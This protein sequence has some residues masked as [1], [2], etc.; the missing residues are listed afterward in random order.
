MKSTNNYIGYS[1][2]LI[3]LINFSI[4]CNKDDNQG[5]HIQFTEEGLQ[6]GVPAVVPDTI[7][8]NQGMSL[9]V[10]GD[11]IEDINSTYELILSG[12]RFSNVKKGTT[13][14]D[15][16]DG[17]LWVVMDVLDNNSNESRVLAIPGR[18]GNLFR[19]AILKYSLKNNRAKQNSNY[20]KKLPSNT[21]S[22]TA[23]DNEYNWDINQSNTIIES[24][25]LS[26]GIAIGTD[27]NG[28]FRL[29]FTDFVLL[30]NSSSPNTSIKIL[31][32][33]VTINNAFDLQAKFNP[34]ELILST[35][36]PII[37]PA[38]SVKEFDSA[39]YSTVDYDLVLGG[40][41][42][43]S[44]SGNSLVREIPLA[45]FIIIVPVS[46]LA[47]IEL[48]LDVFARATLDAVADFSISPRYTGVNDFVA[49]AEYE[50]IGTIPN[51]DFEFT[52]LER[53]T[54][55]A[56]VVNLETS[57]RVE[58]VPQASVY[59]YG[60]VGPTAEL[61]PFVDLNG[62]V[63]Y[64]PTNDLI[65]WDTAIDYGVSGRGTLDINVLGYENNEG[66]IQEL[67]EF[68][69][70]DIINENL[71]HAPSQSQIT[72][73]NNQIG[74]PNAQLPNPIEVLVRDSS[75]NPLSNVAVLFETED[76][77]GTFDSEYVYTDAIGVAVANWTL[78]NAE[79]TQ[80]GR[81]FV[82]DGNG[83]SIEATEVLITAFSGGTDEVQPANSPTPSNGGVSVPLNGTLSFIEG[84][85]TPTDSMFRV[86]FDANPEP[87]TFYDLDVG[88]NTL[89]YSNLE[90]ETQYYWKAETISNTGSVLATSPIWSFTTG[91]NTS[92]GVYVGDVELNNQQE[93]DNFG[94]NN[95]SIITG[96]LQI[97]APDGVDL[98]LNS[99]SSL[100]EI[101]GQLS[102]SCKHCSS[103]QGLSN[104]TSVGYLTLRR[105]QSLP[106]F[107]GLNGLTNVDENVVIGGV[108][109]NKNLN[110][111]SFDG[112][113][114]LATV[115][116]YIYAR[117][118]DQLQN[119]DAFSGLQSV[120]GD[121]LRIRGNI[122]LTDLCGLTNIVVSDGIAGDYSVYENAYNPTE[123]EIIDGN[124]SQ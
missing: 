94:A 40:E 83:D 96:G 119:I 43:L 51:L 110:L 120:D 102:F 25:P 53:S 112:L 76:G 44:G 81:A 80:G 47:F 111:Y 14:I 70:D 92:G 50:G 67:F 77:N 9:E 121:Y 16:L 99:L 21:V 79:G 106:N 28:S 82:L 68:F 61:S 36:D 23:F 90:E 89:D 26:D 42:S 3:L 116:G 5:S 24:T 65:T 71:F 27:A 49:T 57:L 124:C 84:E 103:L 12:E 62:R 78:G 64:N 33:G 8:R 91:D 87:V 45:N 17:R 113:D 30:S 100:T 18:L 46:P 88:S 56:D 35:V 20:D 29:D 37:I 11:S 95:Y 7:I 72:L 10:V 60:L 104:I 19:N 108:F 32:G 98:N 93:V 105:F 122:N 15:N 109:F 73:G 115:G 118:N 63:E 59:L 107:E 34:V 75:G 85:N 58:F 55:A 41:V 52:N 114:N 2:A 38:G 86:Y 123:Q 22:L 54:E 117:G 101:Q 4:S 6:T 97:G 13:I 39:I 1:L 66:G 31:E 48:E 74:E 69:N